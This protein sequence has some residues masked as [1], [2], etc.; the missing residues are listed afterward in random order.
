MSKGIFGYVGRV[1][2]VDLSREKITIEPLDSSMLRKFIGGAGMGAKYLYDE[3]P[4]GVEW[5]DPENRLFA[6]ALLKD[7][8]NR[9][10]RA[11]IHNH[12]RPITPSTIRG[13]LD[14]GWIPIILVDARLVGDEEVPHWVVVTGCS[15]LTMTFHDPLARHGNSSIATRKFN[16]F[17]GFHGTESAVVIMGKS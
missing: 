16:E 4:P 7:L 9:C 14:N 6:L 2:R 13:W 5:S 10:R 3:V 15:R 11:K 8:R 1:L 12:E 17:F